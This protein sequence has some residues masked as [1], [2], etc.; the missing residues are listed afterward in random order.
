M[1]NLFKQIIENTHN[2]YQNVILTW[3]LK[4]GS[5]QK[6]NIFF[7]V[8][9]AISAKAAQVLERS[10]SS[11]AKL[12]HTSTSSH[13]SKIFK[14]QLHS[15]RLACV[16]LTCYKLLWFLFRHLDKVSPRTCSGQSKVTCATSTRKS[17]QNDGTLMYDVSTT[18]HPWRQNQV[19]ACSEYIPSCDEGIS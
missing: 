17:R 1:Q 2:C 13:S 11:S 15:E 10:G 16:W 19:S 12:L 9:Q 18:P 14:M 8:T 5:S 4:S 7:P 6:L 3:T